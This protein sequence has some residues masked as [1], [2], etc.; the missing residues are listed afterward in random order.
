MKVIFL[1]N[2][3]VICLANNWGSRFKKQTKSIAR[4]VADRELPIEE[5]FD[6]FDQKAI[7]VLNSIIEETD[8]EIVISSDWRTWA[9]LE[10]LGQFYLSQGIIK[11]PIALTPLMKDFDDSAFQLFWY[12][13]WLEKIRIVEIKEWLKNNQ[14]DKWVAID[15]LNMS[16][17]A[18]GGYGLENFVLT[19]RSTEGIKQSGK[20][21]EILGYLK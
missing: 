3:G 1:D 19:P 21:E 11:K 13:R 9:T 5:R 14:V 15:D 17:Q 8:A 6:N 18:N 20:K 2:D 10:E 12:K 16:P 4:T 7:K